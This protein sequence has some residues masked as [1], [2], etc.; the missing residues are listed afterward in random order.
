ME[1]MVAM[2][3]VV[4]EGL[5]MAISREEGAME[6]A[7]MGAME[8]VGDMGAMERAVG[9]GAMQGVDME[10]MA[11]EEGE[12]ERGVMMKVGTLAIQ[13]DVW[14]RGVVALR[15]ISLCHPSLYLQGMAALATAVPCAPSTS[16][17]TTLTHTTVHSPKNR[18]EQLC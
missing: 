12:E 2:E 13:P 4:T 16:S 14:L 15:F 18:R 17:P 7:D 8:A 1:A 6:V 10:P 3:V 11:A 5:G 9:M